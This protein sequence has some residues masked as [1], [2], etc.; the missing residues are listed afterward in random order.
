MIHWNYVLG[1]IFRRW[2]R[3]SV[4]VSLIAFSIGVLFVVN[5]IGTSFQQAF[6]APLDDVGATLTV[7]RSGDVPEKME[8][9]VLPCSVAPIH[10]DE[11]RKIAQLPGIQSANEALLIWHFGPEGFRIVVGLR[12]NDESGPALLKKALMSGR[13]LDEA[14]PKAAVVDL[15]FARTEGLEVGQTLKLQDSTFEI[16]GIVDSSLISQLAAAQIYVTLPEARR[17]AVNSPSVKAVHKFGNEDSNVLFVRADRDKTDELAKQIKEIMGEKATV[18]TPASFTEILGGVFALTDRFSWM[19]SA[20]SLA[21]AF[22]LVART[23]AA[24][25]RERR[26]EIGTMKTIGWT[27]RD[28]IRQMGLETVVI[29]VLG[30]LGGVLLGICAANALSLVTISIPIP[31]DMSPRPHFLPGGGDQLMRDVR[32]SVSISPLLVASALFASLLIGVG[33]A[34]AMSRS[35]TRLKPSEVLRYE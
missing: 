30:A 23:T 9:A 10:Q 28:I 19:M 7:Q 3:T 14:N 34:W 24:N 25:V 33:S 8:G 2:R 35:V 1:E 16:A 13:F 21:V 32:L 22:V 27:T 12:S 17:L 18:S 5:T 4:S 11:V 6:R 31:W 20:L 26:P 15:S 29:V